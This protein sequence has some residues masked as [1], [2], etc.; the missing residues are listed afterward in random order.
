MTT[1]RQVS[2]SSYIADIA[3]DE[4]NERNERNLAQ[5]SCARSGGT[6][7]ECPD[8]NGT[9]REDLNVDSTVYESVEAPNN[10]PINLRY[11]NQ[12]SDAQ[13]ATADE[14]NPFANT[15]QRT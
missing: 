10:P 1:S 14:V 5:L 15:A 13:S 7:L 4:R 6:P 12:Q 9:A 2:A 8:N 3:I 11:Q